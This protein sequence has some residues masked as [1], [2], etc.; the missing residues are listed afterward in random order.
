MRVEFLWQWPHALQ[1]PGPVSY[2]CHKVTHNISFA[3]WDEGTQYIFK[4][5]GCMAAQLLLFTTIKDMILKDMMDPIHVTNPK[6]KGPIVVAEMERK[7][8][9]IVFTKLSFL[10]KYKKINRNAFSPIRDT[11]LSAGLDLKSP[12]SCSIQPSCRCLVKINIYIILPTGTYGRIS[13]R[14]SLALHHGINVLAGVIDEDYH[15]IFVYYS[16]IMATLFLEVKGAIQLL[17]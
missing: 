3:E 14:S 13:P 17:N 9:N 1:H 8:Y 2:S 12:Y 6:K 11:T 10:L 7:N 5:K 16:L 15:V 4:L